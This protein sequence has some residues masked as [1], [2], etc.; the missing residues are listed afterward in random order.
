MYSVKI[1]DLMIHL[2]QR[3]RDKCA[4]IVGNKVLFH[5]VNENFVKRINISIANDGYNIQDVI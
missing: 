1:T 2:I 3:I 5:Q 4:K